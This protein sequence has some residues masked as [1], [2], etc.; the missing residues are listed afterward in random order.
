MLTTLENV[1]ESSKTLAASKTDS[2]NHELSAN[3]RSQSR[4]AD[5]SFFLNSNQSYRVIRNSILRCCSIYRLDRRQNAG[6][7]LPTASNT[8][9]GK[10]QQML[11]RGK[12][13][14]VR[15]KDLLCCAVNFKS[16]CL[17]KRDAETDN[18][19]IIAHWK[20]SSFESSLGLFRFRQFHKN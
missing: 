10:H 1:R 6:L 12:R 9:R 2:G 7:H 8:Q 15:C 14:A 19:N 13:R 4:N 5:C 3:C 17:I 16:L 20:F 18:R 11:M